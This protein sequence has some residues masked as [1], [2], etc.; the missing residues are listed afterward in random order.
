LA[1]VG[2]GRGWRGRGR[3]VSRHG[4]ARL[5]QRTLV[6]FVLHGD[7]HRDRLQALEA[8]RGIEV[9]ALLAAVQRGAAFRAVAAV[10]G[11]VGKL[12][13]AVVATGGGHGL[14]QAGKP[15]AG[16]IDG[17][18]GARLP[19]PVVA[20]SLGSVVR[21]VG[22]L[23]APLFISAITIHGEVECCSLKGWRDVVLLS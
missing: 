3:C 7:A 5:E 9:R 12:R 21:A 15:R 23:V 18:T 11:S 2:G 16:Y 13:G 4:Y 22:V 10:I 1:I 19:G 8:R 14:D 6:G 20:I 17:R